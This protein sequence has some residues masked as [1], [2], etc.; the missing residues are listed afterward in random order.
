MGMD[1]AWRRPIC[2]GGADDDSDSLVD[3][4]DPN[5]GGLSGIAWLG[6]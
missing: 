1:V 4:A 2:T 3:C 5:C 6:Q